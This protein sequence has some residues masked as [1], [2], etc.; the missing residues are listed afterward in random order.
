VAAGV[1]RRLRAGL[2]AGAAVLCALASAGLASRYRA[3]AGAG[4][5]EPRPVV[6]VERTLERGSR[7][8]ERDLKAR[9]SRAEIPQRLLPPDALADPQEALGRT[10]VNDIPP[11]S[12]LLASQ[13]RAATRST[14]RRPGLRQGLMPVEA[15]V[16]AAGGATSGAKADVVVAEEPGVTGRARVR[17]VARGVPVLELRRASGA[18]AGTGRWVATLGLRRPQA[19]AV[20][21]AENFAREVRLIPA[22]RR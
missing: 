18:G 21:E 20:I 17:V 14:R 15:Q 3:D 1:S 4:Y 19:L 13:L 9:L 8:R 2:F 22:G 5:G 12:Y 11:G 16:S 10:P 7:L 6:V